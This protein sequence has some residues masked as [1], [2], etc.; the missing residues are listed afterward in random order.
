M[1]RSGGGRLGRGL[2]LPFFLLVVVL[3]IIF[4]NGSRPRQGNATGN[5]RLA[6][7]NGL[8]L[9]GGSEPSQFVVEAE[10]SSG[11]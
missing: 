4:E 8:F 6:S 3:L 5:N 11:S 1:L 7:D 9:V 2:L 10:M